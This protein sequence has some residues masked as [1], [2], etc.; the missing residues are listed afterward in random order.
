MDEVIVKSVLDKIDE[1]E[2]VDLAVELGGIYSPTGKEGP[3]CDYVYDW[4][5]GNGFSPRK[6][7]VYEDR[8]NVLGTLHGAGDGLSMAFNSH[9]D[10]IMSREDAL[11]Y[12]DADLDV[13]HNSWVD[14]QRRVWGVGMVNCKGPMAC[15]LI[16]AK[17]IQ[18]AGVELRGDLLLTAVVGEID[19]EP[20]DEFQGHDYIAEDIG[21]RYMIS[22][23]GI[24]D[25]ALVAE[26]TNFKP[27]WVEAG[28]V[29]FKITLE[30]GPSRYTPYVTH[31]VERSE[32]P[33][34]IVG[35]T[36]AIAVFEE[37][38]R[39]YETRYTWE[40]PGGTVVPKASIGAIRAGLPYK[41]YRQ[42]ELCSM[43]VDIRLNPETSPLTIK[44]ELMDAFASIG[45]R[46]TLEPFL[47]RRGYEA[48]GIE[49]L[50]SAVEAAHHSVLDRPVERPGS[51]EVSMWRDT[52]PF[53]ELG[54]P[55]LT[56][57]PGGGA[58]GG[59]QYFTVDEMVEGAKIYALTALE[60][61]TTKKSK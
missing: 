10:T 49:P 22:H 27:G 50:S 19:Q 32:S 26:A 42:P 60:I 23:G 45:R 61:C 9:L 7:G 13:Y 33:N 52:N 47:Y 41:I 29:F 18:A 20:V 6:V 8:Y 38:A 36:E 44:Q 30:A 56:Y 5:E 4:M 31:P 54:I 59:T 25:Y 21:T 12:I 17:A 11:M 14:D 39:S 57:G 28:K 2:L 58:G 51:P 1:G 15:W 43:Y 46:V 55:S 37:W 3:A 53:N 40:C 16:A 24:A 34:A 48:E 35:M